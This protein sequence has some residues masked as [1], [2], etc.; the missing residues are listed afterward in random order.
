MANEREH[1][2][3]YKIYDKGSLGEVHIAD[4]VIAVIAGIATMEVEGVASMAGTAKDIQKEIISKLGM[5]V[6]SKG[7][8]IKVEDDKVEAD[9][10]VVL[11][12]GKSIPEMTKAIQEKVTTEIENM[13]G[14]TVGAVNVDVVDVNLEN[15]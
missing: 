11:S 15:E 4:E 1:G 8:G 12:Y 5:K 3:S 2:V 14:M 10:S 13:T 9:I 6:L 7:V